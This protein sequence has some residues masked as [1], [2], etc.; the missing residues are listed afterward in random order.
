M[1][2]STSNAIKIKDRVLALV[3]QHV[4]IIEDQ[5]EKY[6]TGERD[7]QG[8]LAKVPMYLS[9]DLTKYLSALSDFIQ[10]EEE[11]I[12]KQLKTLEKM[13]VEDLKKLEDEMN[14]KGNQSRSP[15]PIS[16]TKKKN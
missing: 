1:R 7:D 6:L 10:D 9:Q 4:T 5:M 14:D 13:S 15:K 8:Q 11:E 12:G 2:D 16:S 3:D